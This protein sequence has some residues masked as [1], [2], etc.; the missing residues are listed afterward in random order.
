[1]STYEQVTRDD[2]LAMMTASERKEYLAAQ[3]LPKNYDASGVSQ[4][5]GLTHAP[6]TT[7]YGDGASAAAPV[8]CELCHIGLAGQDELKQHIARSHGG[9]AENPLQYI[10]EAGAALEYRAQSNPGHM[11]LHAKC[12]S[13]LHPSYLTCTA[14]TGA[15]ISMLRYWE[16]SRPVARIFMA[17]VADRRACRALR[18][19][20]ALHCMAKIAHSAIES[21]RGCGHY[22]SHHKCEGCN[23]A[24]C[25]DCHIWSPLCWKCYR[26]RYKLQD[27]AATM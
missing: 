7:T 21:C 2:R 18:A 22:P 25:G 16:A 1:M 11:Q 26:P 15:E 23:I 5:T 19:T 9:L 6:Q 27:S 14:D 3:C 4:H 10:T 24:W 20:W 8:T 12:S 13:L 17:T